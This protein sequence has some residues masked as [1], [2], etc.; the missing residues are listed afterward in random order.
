MQPWRTTV[1]LDS[2]SADQAAGKDLEKPTDITSHFG[3]SNT[4]TELVNVFVKLSQSRTPETTLPSHKL[5]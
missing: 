4:V 2:L 1:R 5:W 3:H